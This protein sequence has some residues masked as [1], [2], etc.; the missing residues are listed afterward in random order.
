MRWQKWAVYQRSMLKD[1]FIY[2]VEDYIAQNLAREVGNQAVLAPSE[3]E[4]AT[5]R[6]IAEGRAQGEQ[7]EVRSTIAALYSALNR[8]CYDDLHVLLL[9]DENTVFTL[10]GYSTAVRP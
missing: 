6:S 7:D 8:K 10:P 5:W 3:W 9:P 4:A 1:K 2:S